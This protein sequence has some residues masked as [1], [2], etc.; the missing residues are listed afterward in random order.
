MSTVDQKSITLKRK[1]FAP[2]GLRVTIMF[3]LRKVYKHANTRL[4]I[5]S[6]KS[7]SANTENRG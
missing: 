3:Y 4:T 5:Q 7:E 2:K 6:W 1:T